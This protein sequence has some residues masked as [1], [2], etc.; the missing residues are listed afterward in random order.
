[1]AI[2]KRMNR[3]G[4]VI[5]YTVVAV[6]PNP[7]GGRG[8]RHVIGTYR[9]RR[10]AEDAERKAKDQI[11]AGTFQPEP[12]EP[13]RVVTVADI[14]TVWFAAKRNS[15]QENSAT[16]YES[17]IR[18]H[19]LPAFGDMAASDL[20]H[21]DVQRQVSAWRDAGMGARLLHRCVMVLRAALARQVKNGTI[22]YN[23]ADG[24]EKP[25]IRKRGREFAVWTD[26]QIDRFLAEAERDRLAPFWFL[27]LIEG[28]RRGE[29]LG[30]RWRDLDWN[31]DETGVT[32]TIAQTVVPDL[33]HGGRALIQDRAK[34][35]SSERPVMLTGDT[36]AVLIAHRDRQRF[37]RQALPDLWGDHD[38]IM[39]TSIGTPITPSSIKRDL[40]AL[41]E[42]AGVPPVTTHGLRHMAATFMLKAG[43]SPALVALKLGHA[44]IGTTVDRYGHLTVNDQ[45][46]VNAVMEAVAARGR[47]TRASTGG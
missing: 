35:R 3:A 43:V 26:P 14:V 12:A 18:L 21:D 41:I 30:L 31:A 47:A 22:P 15:I 2:S 37:A 10:L 46:A 23:V 17:A 33:A 6:V 28:M 4:R 9:T 34:T 45:G 44:D 13:V 16:G 8:T 42:R 32:A 25:V 19:V 36:V 1:M 27:T 38:L 11:Q 20:T 5:G 40:R 39:T 7:R 29:A 24:L